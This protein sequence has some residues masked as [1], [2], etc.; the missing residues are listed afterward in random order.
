MGVLLFASIGIEVITTSLLCTFGPGWVELVGGGYYVLGQFL[1]A[2]LYIR[3][4]RGFA[5]MLTSI[6]TGMQNQEQVHTHMYCR[7][8]WSRSLA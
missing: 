6:G 1:C 4:T 3:S 8:V 5:L 2:V 7:L